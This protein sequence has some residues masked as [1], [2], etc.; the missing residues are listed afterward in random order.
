MDKTD[1]VDDTAF[2]IKDVAAVQIFMDDFP[3]DQKFQKISQ[4]VQ[5]LCAICFFANLASLPDS[6]NHNKTTGILI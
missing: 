1:L 6:G 5:H 3:V 4:T 2:H